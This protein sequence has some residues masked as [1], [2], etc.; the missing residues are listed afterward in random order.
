M[1]STQITFKECNLKM[2]HDEIGYFAAKKI[3]KSC[4]I[5]GGLTGKGF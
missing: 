3:S 2:K 4:I 5:Y 1:S